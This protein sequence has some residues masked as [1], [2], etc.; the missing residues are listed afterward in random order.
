MML[1]YNETL[2]FLFS[3][4][5]MFQ[6]I[7]P[8][9]YKADLDNIIAFDD[10]LGHPHRQFKSIHVAGT[11]GKGS[12]CNMLAA[13]LQKAGYKTGLH[14]S[15]HLKDFRERIRI[16]GACIPEDDVTA[17]ITENEKFIKRKKPSFFEM[18]M[19][20]A[21]DHFRKEKVDVAVIETGMGGRLDSTNI[22]APVVSVITNIGFDHTT[23][24]G[25]THKEIAGEKAGI[26]KQHV[27][28][29]IGETQETFPVFRKK[30]AE[31]DAP[32]FQADQIYYLEK[33]TPAPEGRQLFRVYK[34]NQLIISILDIDLMGFYQQKNIVTT[35]RTIDI[36]REKDFNVS[37]EDLLSGFKNIRTLTGL[38]GRWEII[39]HRPTVICDAGHNPEGIRE[40]VRQIKQ[41]P[42]NHLHFVFGMVDDKDPLPVMELLPK[43]AT[44]YFTRAGIPRA[45]ATEKLV[46]V[47]LKTGLKGDAYPAPISALEAAKKAANPDD[48]VFV[49]GSVFVVAEVL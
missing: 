21:F 22:L 15:P 26:I 17:F 23:F 7:G 11:N 44:Y 16:N 28:V 27:P 1:N 6:R 19:A 32:V 46:E 9:A 24:L 29:V 3:S 5:P 13:V 8:A 18:T 12:V 36:L 49:G 43:T 45:M 34:E 35:L 10:Y 14:T 25:N 41:T 4:L 39:G 47:S 40:V 38:R 33:I 30:A 31:Q 37:E 42:H 48:L 20:M 2:D